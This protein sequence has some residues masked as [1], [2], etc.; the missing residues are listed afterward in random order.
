MGCPPPAHRDLQN[1]PLRLPP[2]QP[3]FLKP[4][5]L[6]RLRLPA[7]PL[8]QILRADHQHREVYPREVYSHPPMP[9][10]HFQA[11]E[12]T[13]CPLPWTP[14]VGSTRLVSD[15]Q[16]ESPCCRRSRSVCNA[17]ISWLSCTRTVRCISRGNHFID[18]EMKCLLRLIAGIH[19]EFGKIRGN[20]LING[21]KLKD[22]QLEQRIGS[23][24][25]Q[26]DQ[27]S[28]PAHLREESFLLPN[29]TVLQYLHIHMGFRPPP[30]GRYPKV[31]HLLFFLFCS[32]RNCPLLPGSVS[33]KKQALFCTGSSGK[34]T[35]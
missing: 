9:S 18:Y 24:I 22:L 25:R 28:F 11:S 21:H 16:A 5:P 12:L 33:S 2:Q 35:G 32:G 17:G 1:S 7:S 8:C 34:G 6:W 29:L 19:R 31:C 3:L 15:C 4:G 23:R 10:E 27:R 30:R 26:F 13:I 14:G 20:F